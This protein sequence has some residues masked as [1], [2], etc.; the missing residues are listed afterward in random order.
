MLYYKSRVA[1]TY[2]ELT[3]IAKKHEVIAVVE[4][5]VVILI[6]ITH[7]SYILHTLTHLLYQHSF[8]FTFPPC[9]IFRAYHD[10]ETS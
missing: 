2:S 6:H 8:D 9:S 7:S 3:L 4:G 1:V 10:L 5:P